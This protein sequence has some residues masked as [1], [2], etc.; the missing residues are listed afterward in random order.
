MPVSKIS[1][2]VVCSSKAGA[3]RWIG[4]TLAGGYRPLLVDRLA[5]HVEDTTERHLADGHA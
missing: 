4:Q 5:E 3:G 1:V 2:S